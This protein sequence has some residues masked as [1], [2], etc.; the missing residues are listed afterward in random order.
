M[1]LIPEFEA[2]Y[3]TSSEDVD[4]GMVKHIVQ[5]FKNGATLEGNLSTGLVIVRD[6]RGEVRG[7]WNCPWLSEIAAIQ[8]VAMSL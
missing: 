8:E 2:I 4:K 5:P 7:Q 6:K 1:V 3:I